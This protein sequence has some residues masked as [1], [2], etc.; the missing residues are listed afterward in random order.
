MERILTPTEDG[1]MTLYIPELN[2]HYHSI[3]GA[4]QESRHIFIRAG[5]EYF[6]ETHPD[7]ISLQNPLHILE[8]GF[9]TGLNA[10]LTLIRTRELQL[11]VCYHSIEKYPLASDEIA[12]LNYSNFTTPAEQELF[13]ELHRCPWETEQS[14]SPYFKLYK[15]REDF[16]NIHFRSQFNI[17]YFDAFNPDVQ[18]HLWTDAVFNRFYEALKPNSILVTYCVKGIVKQALRNV[19]FRLK[20][21]PG[22][23]GKREMLRAVKL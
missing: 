12:S 7:S 17:V 9:G 23:P 21:L 18:P 4:I 15:H 11:P 8:A 20:R 1:S 19:G 2:E 3:H 16:R 22:P 13:N 10:W 5:L 6:L 14:V